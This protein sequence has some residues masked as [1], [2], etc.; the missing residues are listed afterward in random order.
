M[1]WRRPVLGNALWLSV[2]TA[3]VVVVSVHAIRRRLV[4]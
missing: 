1:L 3:I 4:A 2:L